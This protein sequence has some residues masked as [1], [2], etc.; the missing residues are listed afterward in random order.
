VSRDSVHDL[1]KVFQR[2]STESCTWNRLLISWSHSRHTCTHI[3][4]YHQAY[5]CWPCV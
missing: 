2:Y 4:N 5:Q 1:F 3:F